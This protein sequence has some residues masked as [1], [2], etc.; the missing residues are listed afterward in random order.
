VE[1]NCASATPTRNWRTRSLFGLFVL[2]IV[3]SNF[4]APAQ[5]SDEIAADD[6]WQAAA[7]AAS[8]TTAE[9]K[10]DV[11]DGSLNLVVVRD[12]DG[13][14]TIETAHLNSRTALESTLAE[15]K[16]DPSVVSVEPEA[17][18]R[19]MASP[20][21]FSSQWGVSAV[22]S[23][24]VSTTTQGSGV[25]VA[26]IDS[27]VDATNP[28]LAGRVINGV[29]Y[30]DGISYLNS[31][32]LI[33][34]C[35]SYT[36]AVYA[37]KPN[38]VD[39]GKYDPNGH[40]THVAGII[41]SNGIGIKSVAPLATILPIRVISDRGVGDM[42]DVACG[43]IY[44]A[45]HG[46]QVIN[47]SLG[48]SE[49]SAAI[50]AAVAYAI[51]KDVVVV[52]ASGNDGSTG[53]ATYPAALPNVIGVGAVSSSANYP[54]A[55]FSNRG[56]YVD[57]VA[58]G[59]GIWSTCSATPISWYDGTT[60]KYNAC[61][62]A[63]GDP[64]YE[65]LNGT[66][67]ASPFAAGLAALILGMDSNLRY[68]DVASIITSSAV[69]KGAAGYDQTYGYGL[70][71]APAAVAQTQISSAII[72]QQI[73]A[74]QA[75]TAEAARVAAASQAASEQAAAAEVAR[76][77]SL[78]VVKQSLIVKV[79]KKKKISISVAAPIGSTTTIQRKVGNKWK[80][81]VT[82]TT[83]PS[84]VA[85]VSKAGTYRVKIKISTGTITTKAYNVK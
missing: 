21:H 63:D 85:K 8:A 48:S 50:R 44:A 51:A 13:V 31:S 52:A 70:I 24:A 39:F 65:S 61:T 5:A 56:D 37:G 46:A 81:V 25:I 82:T 45:D 71:N 74:E 22:N 26:V 34:H 6:S 57:V 40:G 29:D 64:N 80:N 47:M 7:E 49:D 38:H 16:S 36:D 10:A 79:L 15:L 69:D 72:A 58:P 2:A 60:W 55:S 17:Q 27:G 1:S 28:D 33:D 42:S 23:E 9:L 32:E 20:P 19:L 43:I 59:V 83:V 67:M 53:I 14:P 30:R 18:V 12:V 3:S 62:T 78:P 84:M 11:A 73:A 76:L 54:I 66:S 68:S 35:V 75:A 4:L 41:S 77:A